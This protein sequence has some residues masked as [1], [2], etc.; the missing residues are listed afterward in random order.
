MCVAVCVRV[1]PKYSNKSL[2][3]TLQFTPLKKKNPI[4]ISRVIFVYKRLFS[5]S[6][7]KEEGKMQHGNSLRHAR[8]RCVTRRDMKE[9]FLSP[10]VTG[11]R[12][13]AR[14]R[15]F[16]CK[17]EDNKVAALARTSTCTRPRT[18]SG[19]VLIPS[20]SDTPFLI[21]LLLFAP[22]LSFPPLPTLHR[23]SS[24]L[25]IRARSGGKR[26]GVDRQPPPSSR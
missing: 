20:S 3:R 10:F 11:A 4:L 18:F 6:R 5:A 17:R 19:A 9:R 8:V 1:S 25:P 7:E 22:P 2:T 23:A 13:R 21:L 16:T 12:R 24:L 15:R 26:I 14:A